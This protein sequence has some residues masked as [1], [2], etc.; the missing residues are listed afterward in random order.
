MIG[1][2]LI[3]IFKI[4]T[5]DN[6]DYTE[7]TNGVFI[8]FHNLNDDTYEKLENYVDHIYSVH[9]KLVNYNICYKVYFIKLQFYWHFQ[10]SQKFFIFLTADKPVPIKINS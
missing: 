8:F 7:N 10:S 1:N 6:K 3:N 2:Y 9:N 5:K 4:I